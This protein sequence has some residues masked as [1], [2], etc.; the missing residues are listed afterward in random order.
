[1]TEGLP[2]QKDNVFTTVGKPRVIYNDLTSFAIRSKRQLRAA[3]VEVVQYDNP[4]QCYS[5]EV[6]KE[7]ADKG[8]WKL[9]PEQVALMP[10]EPAKFTPQNSDVLALINDRQGGLR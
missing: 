3:Q 2:G 10:Q 9:T 5:D 6:L 7:M 8:T 1:M 4:I